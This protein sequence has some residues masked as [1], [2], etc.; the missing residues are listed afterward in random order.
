MPPELARRDRAAARRA[1]DHYDL[2]SRLGADGDK[3]FQSHL[4]HYS[5]KFWQY[6]E[7]QAKLKAMSALTAADADCL[8]MALAGTPSVESSLKARAL[9]EYRRA[10]YLYEVYILMTWTSDD[11]VPATFPPGVTKQNIENASPQAVSSTLARVRQY[12]HA[13][14]RVDTNTENRREYDHLLQRARLRIAL[15]GADSKG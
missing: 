2:A 15:L 6:H 3:E 12:F 4:E 14:G 8:R 10:Q 7:H 9:S 1:I 13:T 5:M 11:T